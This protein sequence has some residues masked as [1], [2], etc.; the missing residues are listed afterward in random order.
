MLMKNLLSQTSVR[1]NLNITFS[2]AAFTSKSNIRCG[3]HGKEESR[4][5]HDE[6]HHDHPVKIFLIILIYNFVYC[7]II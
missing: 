3:A 2:R 6:E 5:H 1:K 4:D 7:K